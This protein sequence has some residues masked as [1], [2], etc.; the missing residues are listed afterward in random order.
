MLLL[1]DTTKCGEFDCFFHTLFPQREQDGPLLVITGAITP[2]S[3]VFSSKLL[4]CKAI[5]RGYN[6]I[7]NWIGA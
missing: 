4:I 5:Y 7:C 3:R 2:I 6:P 1:N